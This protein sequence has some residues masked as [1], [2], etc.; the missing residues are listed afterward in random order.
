MGALGKRA[1]PRERDGSP[2]GRVRRV[3]VPTSG[4]WIA[5]RGERGEL[6]AGSALPRRR[7]DPPTLSRG[8][9]RGHAP[10]PPESLEGAAARW[11]GDRGCTGQRA[12]RLRVTFGD[13]PVPG[14][15]RGVSTQPG[16][17]ATGSHLPGP[18]LQTMIRVRP[19]HVAAP[20]NRSRSRW[21]SAR[22][23]SRR[24]CSDASA[25][26]PCGN[27]VGSGSRG[28]SRAPEVRAAA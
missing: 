14:R 13:G 6:A 5:R 4:G 25:A 11:R 17:A 2:V 8:S 21:F 9:I 23:V 19:Q 15:S 7:P 24:W 12:Q 3:S 22:S 20:W 27:A 26:P 18:M 28:S 1:R 16:H 10:P